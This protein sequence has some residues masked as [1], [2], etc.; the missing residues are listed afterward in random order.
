MKSVQ[1]TK[2]KTTIIDKKLFSLISRY[3]WHAHGKDRSVYACR[4]SGGKRRYLHREVMELHLERSINWGRY[5]VDHLNGDSLDN[6]LANLRLCTKHQNAR[7]RKGWGRCKYK[8][9]TLDSSTGLYIA[10]ITYNK[11]TRYLGRY[12]TAKEAALMYDQEAKRLHK[13]FARLNF[14]K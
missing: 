5:V 13:E 4:G 2:G 9:V 1:L 8:G 7:N 14:T 11:K 10:K 3:S 6:R 12:R